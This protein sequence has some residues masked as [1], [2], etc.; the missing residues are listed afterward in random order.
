[1]TADVQSAV[2]GWEKAAF[3]KLAQLG[4][5]VLL[6]TSDDKYLLQVADADDESEEGKLRP[7][8]GCKDT[9]DK[10]LTETIVREMGEEFAL[11][12]SQVAKKIRFLG[13][14]YRDEFKGNAVFEFKNHGL[15]PGVYQASNDPDEKVRLVE[16]KLT[17]KRYVGPDPDKLLDA[18]DEDG[19][20]SARYWSSDELA[21]AGKDVV[22]VTVWFGPS[23]KGVD[24]ITTSMSEGES[25]EDVGVRAAKTFHKVDLDDTHVERMP[26]KEPK[27][28]Q[29]RVFIPN[30]KQASEM[31]DAAADFTPDLSPDEIE[32][33]AEA[34]ARLHYRTKPRLASMAEWPEDWTT[35]QDP[36]GWLSWYQQYYNG[37]R[38]PEDAKQIARWKSF[39]ARQSAAFRNHPTPRRGWALVNWAIDPLKQLPAEE[40]ANFAA[41]MDAFKR[42]IDARHVD[43]QS[44]AWA[45]AASGNTEAY[46]KR[47]IDDT[48][49][50]QMPASA[51]NQDTDTP[52]VQPQARLTKEAAAYLE[53]LD[54]SD[55]VY[56]EDMARL[57]PVVKQG[58]VGLAS[59]STEFEPEDLTG[60]EKQASATLPADHAHYH[61]TYACGHQETCCRTLQ[62]KIELEDSGS[63]PNCAAKL[64]AGKAASTTPGLE[65]ALPAESVVPTPLTGPEAIQH[66]LGRLDLDKLE[67]DAMTVV[68]KKLKSKRPD[69]V[70][71]L[72]YVKGLRTMGYHP[73]DLMLTRVPVIPPQFRPYAV[74]GDTFVPGDSNELYRDLINLRGVHTE[75]EGKLGPRGAA[76]NKLN[77]YDAVSALYGFGDPTSPK[78]RE[79]GVSGFLKK[80]VGPSPKYGFVQRKLLSKNQDFVG[81]AVIGVDPDL[82]LDEI[83]VPDEQLWE[84]LAPH[85]QRRLVRGGMTPSEALKAIKERTGHA[86]KALD[87][88]LSREHGRPII[89]SRAPSWHKYNVVAGWAKRIP[90]NTVRINNLVTTGLNADFDGDTLNVHAPASPDAVKDAKE[91][92]M[93]SKMLFSIKDPD[94]VVPL[95]KQEMIL[96]LFTAQR[97]PAKRVFDFPDE[98]TALAAIRSGKVSMS[99]EVTIKGKA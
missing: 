20:K 76:F 34:V 66:A 95:P 7:P 87:I 78:T 59:L 74:A 60:K 39:N 38:N 61:K 56:L 98:Q 14:E 33:K 3:F 93:P 26:E 80:V 64:V 62:P 2:I 45:K 69:A 6:P 47:E 46:I 24:R 8:G 16:A 17:S 5:I 25:L 86:S 27:H 13:Y 43:R 21:E 70:K 73:K 89:Y 63:C 31:L 83:A 92:L 96:G 30:D 77:I 48:E 44:K 49:M 50:Q 1:M 90:G 10:N 85:V 82:G 11:T 75:L 97:R 72:G 22:L 68:R 40:Q 52:V 84:M 23:V 54:A 12:R 99:D 41:S 35:S 91:K 67:E 36:E 32:E 71:I 79:R 57:F 58:T 42:R 81:R 28:K 53:F 65:S 37:R 88:E 29:V 55:A 9:K 94:K 19:I 51:I 4:A 15:K 18:P